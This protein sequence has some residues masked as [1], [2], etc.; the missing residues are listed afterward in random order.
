[1]SI[2]HSRGHLAISPAG[3]GCLSKDRQHP[4]Q[5]EGRQ[6]PYP[7]LAHQKHR[8]EEGE[9]PELCKPLVGGVTKTGQRCRKSI[10]NLT[11]NGK[12]TLDTLTHTLARCTHL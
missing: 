5:D 11:G 12:G 1:M 3:P 2:V 10:S 6:P 7:L 8:V 4:L 9:V